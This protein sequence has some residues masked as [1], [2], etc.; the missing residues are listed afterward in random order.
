MG[1]PGFDEEFSGADDGVVVEFGQK[2]VGVGVVVSGVE[3]HGD[4]VRKHRAG[5][6]IE[7]GQLFQ[8]WLQQRSVVAVRSSDHASDR[9]AL[10][11]DHE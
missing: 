10:P 1:V 9:D 7:T 5:A 3:V 8:G 11:L 6:L 4:R 2:V